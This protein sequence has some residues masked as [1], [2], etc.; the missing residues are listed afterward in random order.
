MAAT[1]EKPLA[2]LA[3]EI[4]TPPFSKR[5]RIE[6]GF[7]LRRLQQ[8]E[9]LTMPQSGPMP[10]IGPRC[11]ELRVRDA[12]HSWRIIYRTDTDAI[13]IADVFDK[14]TPKT[15]KHVVETCKR[16]LGQYDETKR[17]KS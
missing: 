9:V 1:D 7:L 15:P 12:D 16:R 10:E 11:H 3:G 14:K 4:K 8:G 13:V 2:W 5:A 6:A 17:G